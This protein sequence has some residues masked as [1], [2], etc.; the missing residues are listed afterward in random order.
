LIGLDV[1]GLM[2][3]GNRGRGATSKMWC[4]DVAALF[5]AAIL[6]RKPDSVVIP[7]D[8]AA[9]DVRGDPSDSVL[10]LSARSCRLSYLR[11][12]SSLAVVMLMSSKLTWPLQGVR[13]RNK[14]M[15]TAPSGATMVCLTSVQA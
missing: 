1:S 15:R 7:F 12:A 4:M 14:A 11:A 2:A 6:R 5:V 10:S 9:Y 3:T 13:P 8:T